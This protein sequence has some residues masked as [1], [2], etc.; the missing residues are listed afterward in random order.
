METLYRDDLV[1]IVSKECK[2]PKTTIKQI[3]ID[4]T[5]YI[6]KQTAEQQT[7]KFIHL[8]YVE[9]NENKDHETLAYICSEL[10]KG[11][12][13]SGKTVQN[14]LETYEVSLLNELLKGKGISIYGVAKVSRTPN[15]RI[16]KTGRLAN[17][18][19]RVKATK[20]LRERVNHYDRKNT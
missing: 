1:E 8:F 4:Y 16:R 12:S 2:L 17:K 20:W 13:Y 9:N 6:Y 10:A 15:L 5:N 18:G 14:V 11:K 19:Y 7:V 3:I